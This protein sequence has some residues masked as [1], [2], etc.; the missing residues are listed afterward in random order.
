MIISLSSYMSEVNFSIYLLDKFSTFFHSQYF[1]HREILDLWTTGFRRVQSL[2]RLKPCCP[3]YRH[4]DQSQAYQKKK[5]EKKE[6]IMY[7]K[8]NKNR[9]K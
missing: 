3:L 4:I 2:A 5:E 1:I 7:N 9:L 6:I 8:S